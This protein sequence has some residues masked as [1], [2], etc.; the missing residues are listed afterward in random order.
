MSKKPNHRCRI[1]GTEYYACND[2]ASRLK[3]QYGEE[4]WRAVADTP[5]HYQIYVILVHFVRKE[6]SA[7]EALQQLNHVGIG[8][9]DTFLLNYQSLI[10]RVI[11]EA[12]AAEQEHTNSEP[13]AEQAATEYAQEMSKPKPRSRKKVAKATELID[14]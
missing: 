1:C 4:S 9:M 6:I 14:A 13:S 5:V 7:T 10:Q 12:E 8:D 2:C 11:A 3:A